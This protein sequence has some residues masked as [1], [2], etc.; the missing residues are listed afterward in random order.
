MDVGDPARV[1]IP[2]G[3]A[4]VLRA[5]ISAGDAHMTM[6]QVAR[7]AGVSAPVARDLLLRLADHGLVT[8]TTVGSATMCRYNDAHLAAD[9]VRALVTLRSAMLDLLRATIA[10]WTIQPV[11]ASL[12]GSAAR[13]DGGV[14]SDLDVL[15]VRPDDVEIGVWEDQLYDAGVL[16]QRRT[17]NPVAWF[18]VTSPEMAAMAAAGESVV[19]GWRADGISLAGPE[20]R[21]VLAAATST[22]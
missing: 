1:L 16:I 7:V 2:A 20:V 19:D 12:F 11:H 5:L 14:N 15:V 21:D 8:A 4:A 6:R 18:D 22:R 9:A 3:T 10:V 17:G 13:G